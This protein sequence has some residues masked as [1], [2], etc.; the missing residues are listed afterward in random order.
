MRG[1][2]DGRGRPGGRAAIW[3]EDVAERVIF[4]TDRGSTYTANAFTVLCRELGIRQSMGR[5]G[6]CFDNAAA[7]AFF[8]VVGVEVCPATSSVILSMRRPWSSNGAT[9][10]TITNGGT[11]QQMGYRPSTTRSGN[12]TRSR[13]RLEEPSTI[14]GKHKLGLGDSGAS[15]SGITVQ[16]WP[17][18]WSLPLWG[19][20]TGEAALC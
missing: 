10:S 17:R 13:K 20:T 12:Q 1:D 8:S 18:I 9:T 16:Q 19:I 5:V 14:S 2:H 3:R 7:E 11:L 6:S 4:H 15:R